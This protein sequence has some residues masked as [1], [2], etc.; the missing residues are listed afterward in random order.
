MDERLLVPLLEL[1][2]DALGDLETTMRRAKMPGLVCGLCGIDP[3][4][5]TLAALA[6]MGAA[7][8]VLLGKATSADAGGDPGRTVG[9]AAA[10][11]V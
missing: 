6:Q 8:G 3:V 10:V 7:R 4:L 5:F 9:Y 2:G 1:D 11:F